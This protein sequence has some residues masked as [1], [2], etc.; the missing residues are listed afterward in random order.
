MAPIGEEQ[1]LH[2]KEA[3]RIFDTDNDGKI[4]T[5]ASH[6]SKGMPLPPSPS[7]LLLQ[8]ST[9]SSFGLTSSCCTLSVL[10]ACWAE[11][12]LD[13]LEPSSLCIPRIVNPEP[14]TPTPHPTR[15]GDLRRLMLSFGYNHTEEVSPKP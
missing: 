2:I 11:A 6:R 10:P 8:P 12:T 9:P 3:W 1:W 14:Q 5:G 7:F 15:A 4:T 13:T